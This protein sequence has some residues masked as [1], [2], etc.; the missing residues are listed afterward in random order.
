MRIRNCKRCGGRLAADQKARH[1]SCP[2]RKVED[3]TK[4]RALSLTQACWDKLALVARAFGYHAQG[5]P[6]RSE[7]ARHVIDNFELGTGSGSKE[8]DHEG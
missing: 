1:P 5:Q 6:S 2:S 8:G 4:R 3:P 7:A